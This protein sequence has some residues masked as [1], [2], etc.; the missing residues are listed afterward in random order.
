MIDPIA[1]FDHILAVLKVRRKIFLITFGTLLA[2]TLLFVLTTPKRYTSHAN[3]IVGM[4]RQPNTGDAP[5][6]LPILNALM[7]VSGIQ[8]GETYSELLTEAPVARDVIDRLHLNTTPN[9][10]LQSVKA[11]PINNTSIVRITATSKTPELSAD[12]ANGF[13]DSFIERERDLV[14]GQATAAIGFLSQE[15]PAAAARERA[16][17]SALTSFQ[18]SHQITDVGMQASAT[19]SSLTSLD[20]KAAQLQLDQR[21]ASAQLQ[22]DAVQLAATGVTTPSSQST[23]PNPVVESLNTQLAQVQTQLGEARRTYTER[24]PAVIALEQQQAEI[25]REIARQ[26]ATVVSAASTSIN[27][28]YEQLSQQAAGYRSQIAA[29]QAGLTELATQRKVLL[30]QMRALPDETVQFAAL[31]RNAKEGEAVYSALQQRL[32]DAMIAKSTAISD[33]TITQRASATDA[34]ANPSRTLLLALG[35]LLSLLLAAAAIAVLEMLDRRRASENA[36]RS[37]FGANVLGVIPDLSRGEGES[38]PALRAMT[39]ESMLQI[40]RLLRYSDRKRVRSI[41]FTS[42]RPGDG[43]S[44]VAVNVAHT[45][46]ELDAPVLLVDGD[47]RRP[48]LHRI[49]QAPNEIGLADVLKNNA[50]P[51][52]AI[53]K[54]SIV[55]LDVLTSGL[56]VNNPAQLLHS[57][58]LTALLTDAEIL[59]YQTVIFDLPAVLPVVDAAMIAEKVDGTVLVV[60]AET[61]GAE[62]VRESLEHIERAGIKNLLGLIVN[63]VRRDA[64]LDGGY[65]LPAAGSPLALP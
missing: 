64:T 28:V 29:D 61:S 36:I 16:A 23:A 12:I 8:S 26:P 47:L 15:M 11:E 33:V 1:V 37:S 2:L 3:V 62:F 14:A 49:L 46:A 50:S 63:R 53:R 21:Q 9:V 13:A 35:L 57:P 52:D 59:G 25:Q 56:P 58:A 45:L 27:P 7:I 40:V 5:T 18:R 30:G 6:N 38:L 19:I 39:L 44:T 4:G 32:S 10:L 55:G 31:Q 65:Y 51:E 43:K 22:S 54:T 42:P 17:E 34:I 41:A 48:A 20:V 60:S 24:H